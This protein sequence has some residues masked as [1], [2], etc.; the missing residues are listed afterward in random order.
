[1][2]CLPTQDIQIKFDE[3]PLNLNVMDYRGGVASVIQIQ[4]AEYEFDKNDLLPAL[5]I[6]IFGEKLSGS[7]G[8]LYD[9][10]NYKLLDSEG[11][12]VQTGEI[13]LDYLNAGDR[14]RDDSVFIYDITP[15][16]TYTFQLYEY[17][18]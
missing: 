13:F 12:V 5:S 11:Y 17:N 8:I 3:F 16:E 2:Y 4:G 15:G 9:S 7:G 18:G 10:F 6:T 14:F 1:M